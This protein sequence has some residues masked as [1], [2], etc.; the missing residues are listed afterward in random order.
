MASR[1]LFKNAGA[2]LQPDGQ[3]HYH[4]EE[5]TRSAANVSIG[6]ISVVATISYQRLKWGTILVTRRVSK[7][8]EADASVVA[9]ESRR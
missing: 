9:P 3:V 2:F 5:V 7:I 8:P 1:Q 4:L 6:P